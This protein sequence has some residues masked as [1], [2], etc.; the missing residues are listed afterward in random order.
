MTEYGF[1]ALITVILFFKMLA[2]SVVQGRA[3]TSSKT[4]PNPGRR[5][6]SSERPRR[7]LMN[8]RS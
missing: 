1:Y 6:Y 3:R 8:C 7:R 2:N 5:E 4:F